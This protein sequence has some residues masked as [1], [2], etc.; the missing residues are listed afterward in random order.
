[1]TVH[2]FLSNLENV[3]EHPS[4]WLA[5]CPNHLPS[6]NRKLSVRVGERVHFL[7][8]CQSH[9]PFQA[10]MAATRKRIAGTGVL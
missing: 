2:E 1:M 10:I 6:E 4:G 5:R 3:T 7:A 8:R 9:C